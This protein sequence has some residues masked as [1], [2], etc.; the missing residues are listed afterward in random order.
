MA[1]S[2]RPAH[3]VVSHQPC[4][5]DRP[6]PAATTALPPS[7]PPGK[8]HRHQPPA[9]RRELDEPRKPARADR[10]QEARTP[11]H[12]LHAST[13][14]LLPQSSV[15]PLAIFSKQKKMF[16]FPRIGRNPERADEGSTGRILPITAFGDLHTSAIEVRGKNPHQLLPTEREDPDSP[17]RPQ[18]LPYMTPPKSGRPTNPPTPGGIYQL[19][20]RFDALPVPFKVLH[21]LIAPVLVEDQGPLF[22]HPSTSDPFS[23]KNNSGHRTAG[24]RFTR[25]PWHDCTPSTSVSSAA[26][27]Y[28]YRAGCSHHGWLARERGRHKNHWRRPGAHTYDQPRPASAGE[29][30][31]LHRPVVEGAS[32]FEPGQVGP[33]S[34]CCPRGCEVRVC[35]TTRT[36]APPRYG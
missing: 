14:N 22:G 32:P 4:R 30:T 35:R 25:P 12:H 21:T 11:A 18:E 3:P 1:G 6:L 7:R 19:S 28:G 24:H 10:V 26:S 23:K 29:A 16:S 20:G 36:A 9:R 5:A 33:L 13:D 17:S 34:S 27:R 31:P 15:P 2:P 8:D